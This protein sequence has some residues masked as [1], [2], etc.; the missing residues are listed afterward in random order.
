MMDGARAAK[1][2]SSDTAVISV[3]T[4]VGQRRVWR[5]QAHRGGDLPG[6]ISHMR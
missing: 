3:E 2:K 4:S 5:L 6:R 1:W